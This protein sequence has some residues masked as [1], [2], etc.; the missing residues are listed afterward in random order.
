MSVN[1]PNVWEY[2]QTLMPRMGLILS[3]PLY[4]QMAIRVEVFNIL[5]YMILCFSEAFVLYIFQFTDFFMCY[6]VLL[7]YQPKKRIES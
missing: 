2:L 6:M 4:K 7:H 1:M 3:T 5:V